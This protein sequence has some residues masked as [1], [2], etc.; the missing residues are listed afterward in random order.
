MM[1]V[2]VYKLTEATQLI[3]IAQLNNNWPYFLLW[4]NSR[5]KFIITSIGIVLDN[6][7]NA[8]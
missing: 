6:V 4:R 5:E 3:D 8:G 7:L 1:R 2:F